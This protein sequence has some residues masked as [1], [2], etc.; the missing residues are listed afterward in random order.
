MLYVIE[1]KDGEEWFPIPFFQT[2]G[3]D[4][5]DYI[6]SCISQNHDSILKTYDIIKSK[7]HNREF[8]VKL[9]KRM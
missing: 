6:H 8:R 1:R 4:D 3:R 5:A 7:F 9:Y 2:I